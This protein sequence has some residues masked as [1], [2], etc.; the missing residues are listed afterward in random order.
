[1]HTSYFAFRWNSTSQLD[2]YII[3]A[4]Q[5]RRFQNLYEE[6]KIWTTDILYT[7]VHVIF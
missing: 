5:R 3:R 7:Y 6:F 4:E 2:A 1:M